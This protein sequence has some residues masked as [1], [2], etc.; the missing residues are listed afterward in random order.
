MESIK[1]NENL[2]FQS[3]QHMEDWIFARNSEYRN[4]NVTV[5][6]EVYDQVY[7]RYKELT[8][9]QLVDG[10]I[11]YTKIDNNKRE[12]F[13]IPMAGLEKITSIPEFF[14]WIEKNNLY[15]VQL[16]AT[17][18]YDGVSCGVINSEI[19]TRFNNGLKKVYIKGENNEGYQI[20]NHFQHIQSGKTKFDNLYHIGEV[21]MANNLFERKYS[22]KFKNVRNFTA[23]RLNPNSCSTPEL[24]DFTYIRYSIES[25]E[26]ESC[27]GLFSSKEDILSY[28]NRFNEVKVPYLK[29]MVSGRD[30]EEVIEKFFNEIYKNWNK[31][32]AIDGVVVDVNSISIRNRLGRN[33]I[34]NPKFAVAYKG[35]FGDIA[36]VGIK[37]INYTL[38]KDGVINPSV[39]TD[40]VMLDGAECGKNIFVD[41]IKYLRDN[42]IHVGKR[43]EIKRGGK[44]IPRI[45]KPYVGENQQEKY[46]YYSDMI[47]LGILP[48]RCPS[49]G[50]LLVYDDTKVDVRC[51]NPECPEKSKRRILFFFETIKAKGISTA[52]ISK[53]I[54]TLAVNRLESYPYDLSLIETILMEDDLDSVLYMDFGKNQS[55]IIRESII[56]AISE[57]PLSRL[58]AATN[59]FSGLGETKIGWF[60]DHYKYDY[61]NI[62]DLFNRVWNVEDINAVA[63]YSNIT[64][65]IVVDNIQMFARFYLHISDFISRIKNSKKKE[66]P[67]ITVNQSS[68]IDLSNQSFCFTGF[69]NGEMEK[70]IVAYK[71]EVKNSF[72]SKTTCLVVKEKGLGTVKE[73]KALEK[74]IKVMDEVEMR[75]FLGMNTIVE[76]E[77]KKTIEKSDDS[78]LW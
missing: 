71:G 57:C 12:K 60:L 38:D 6:D 10:K 51:N 7:R 43:I 39:T 67:K 55:R 54:D 64:S 32:F 35:E 69:R 34:G 78:P 63:G 14:D 30:Q 3:F 52:T 36:E 41:N 18:K 15:K 33:T 23:G 68:S 46:E 75:E 29:L 74:G 47:D 73:K 27:G 40:L 59:L 1:I 28:L 62:E 24:K 53:F 2:E 48:N 19:E 37:S 56:S 17:P 11:Q 49:C 44:I 22:D 65:K 77:Q 5:S 70:L 72:T 61:T 26:G 21:I 42:G 9:V 76:E 25:N 58:M 31:E 45:Y 4:G 8:G 16:I 20:S 66:E 13:P 50:S